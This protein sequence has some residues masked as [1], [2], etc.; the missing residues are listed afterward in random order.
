M[1]SSQKEDTLGGGKEDK[2]NKIFRMRYLLV[3]SSFGF[4][5]TTLFTTNIF[6][7]TL[8]YTASLI[9][10]LFWS[11]AKEHST[12]HV[13]DGIM[14]RVCIL[15]V[16]FYKFFINTNNLKLF[17]IATIILFYFIYMSNKESTKKWESKQH[18]INHFFS[19]ILLII[20][21]ILAFI[22]PLLHHSAL[23]MPNGNVT[24]N[25]FVADE[26]ALKMRKGVK[27]DIFTGNVALDAPTMS[28]SEPIIFSE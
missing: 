3:C 16:I 22:P 10:A 23:K 17:T 28:S 7:I 6:F 15:S 11:E 14:A 24:F 2:L 26:S 5:I 20:C 18:I 19:H 4:I 13:M 8:I 9:S 12:I 25:S 21:G 1:I 27:S